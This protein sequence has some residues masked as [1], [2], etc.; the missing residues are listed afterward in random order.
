MSI[1]WYW[2]WFELHERNEEPLYSFVF[3]E[4]PNGG[5]G[6]QWHVQREAAGQTVSRPVWAGLK[7]VIPADIK[8][9]NTWNIWWFVLMWV[10]LSPLPPPFRLV[11]AL[12]LLGKKLNCYKVTLECAAKNVAFYQKFGYT[13]SDESYMQCRFFD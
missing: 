8:V 6:S 9:L 4:R 12:T 13:A 1:Y 3:S 7:T 2:K 5:G 10:S 11:S